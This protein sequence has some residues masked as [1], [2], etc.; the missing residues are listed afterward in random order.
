MAHHRSPLLPRNYRRPNRRYPS[1]RRK[2]LAPLPHGSKRICITRQ[3]IYLGPPLVH[4]FESLCVVQRPQNDSPLN[5]QEIIASW[6]L[7]CFF[8]N[9]FVRWRDHHANGPHPLFGILRDPEA[10]NHARKARIALLLV[11]CIRASRPFYCKTG[12]L[13]LYG[14]G[15]P[16]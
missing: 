7:W 16:C 9:F 6:Q 8:G 4:D 1:T 13:P 12:L 10:A 2:H 15:H 3:S 11:G 14:R 5:S